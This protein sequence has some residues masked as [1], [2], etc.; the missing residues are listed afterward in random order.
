M[1]HGDAHR[2]VASGNGLLRQ[3]VP[4]GAQYD[5]Q[6]VRL[7][8]HRILDAHGTVAQ[9]HG[10]RLEAQLFQAFQPWMGP[11]RRSFPDA[12]PRRLEDR[13]HAHPCRPSI[14][15]VAAGGGD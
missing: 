3:T 11:I 15:G 12:R 5:G 4:L 9:R 1:G 7:L 13:P 10:R 6:L 2:V 8:Q 14:E